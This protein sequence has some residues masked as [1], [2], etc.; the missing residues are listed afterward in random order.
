MGERGSSV[1]RENE[2][3]LLLGGERRREKCQ[4]ASL[5]RGPCSPFYQTRGACYINAMGQAR[6]E[7]ERGRLCMISRCMGE[8]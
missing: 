8:L 4:P 5:S 3:E 2:K 6:R 7:K 1:P